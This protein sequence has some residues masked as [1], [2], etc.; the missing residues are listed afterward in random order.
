MTYGGGV[1]ASSGCTSRCPLLVR[2]FPR[3]YGVGQLGWTSSVTVRPA[4]VSGPEST[5]T[6]FGG[7]NHRFTNSQ[8]GIGCATVCEKDFDENKV[9]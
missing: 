8:R 1:A 3:F 4:I 5:M 6:F 7:G 2:G 9:G